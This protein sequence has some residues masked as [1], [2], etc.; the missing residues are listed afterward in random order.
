MNTINER[1]KIATLLRNKEGYIKSK[2][3]NMMKLRISNI[4]WKVNQFMVN[5]YCTSSDNCR[6]VPLNKVFIDSENLEEN[7]IIYTEVEDKAILYDEMQEKLKNGTL[8]DG[9]HSF[10]DLYRQRMILSATICNLIPEKCWK[11]KKHSDGQVCFD[12]TWFIIGFD[13]S[14]G[15]YSYHYELKYWDLFKCKELEQA[16]KF[17]GHTDKD[18]GRLLSLI[19]ENNL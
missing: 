15:Q 6:N 4:N 5:G 19:K 13:T 2:K 16:P 3:G 11:S 18:V 12:G 9:Y 10:N 17:D 8:S 14:E 7:E 1:L